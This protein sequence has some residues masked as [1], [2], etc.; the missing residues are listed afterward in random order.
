MTKVAAVT[1]AD[2]FIGSHL[3]QGLVER[4]YNVKALSQY[5]SF[6]SYG[7]LDSLP[8]DVMAS[9]QVH[10]GDVRD[11][12]SILN[13]IEDAE[14]VYHLAALIAVPYSYRAPQS[15]ID[16]NVGG[17]LNVLEAARALET[18]RLVH[19]STSETYGTARTISITE[20]HPL[21][22]QSP[23]AATKIAADK[24]VESY[25]LSFDLPV[26]TLRPFNTY[27]PRQSTRAV[28]P[29]IIAQLAEGC[30]SIELGSLTP[31]RDFM[32]VSDTVG[33][34]LALSEAE[35]VSVVGSVLNAGTG[36][37]TTIAELAETIATIM[38]VPLRVAE[39]EERK[40]PEASE[41][42]R[43]VCDASELY[44]RTGWRPEVDLKAGLAQTIEWFRKPETLE[45]MNSDRI[46]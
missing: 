45:L 39:Q 2:G 38:D 36:V 17:T 1:G 33:A 41:V 22:A 5:N 11:R 29:T 12:L 13:L 6:G 44:S 32:F 25:H 14:T 23:Y 37:E 20:D 21:Q 43:L 27:G 3:V 46:L 19:T 42:E 7:W 16:T 24:L 31:A 4:D 9:V 8:A 15:Y 40:R 26:V 18:P 30:G 34:F 28:I 35:S 10:A